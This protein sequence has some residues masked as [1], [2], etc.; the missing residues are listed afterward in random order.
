MAEQKRK[1]YY[2][3]VHGRKP[4]I[5]NKWFGPDGA[6]EQ[7]QDFP[8]AIYKGFY[9][10]EEMRQWLEQFSDTPLMPEHLTE[11]V[12]QPISPSPNEITTMLDDSK[13]IIYTDGAAI[14]NPGSGGY[15]VVLL[16]KKKRKE[17][18]GGFRLTTNN[19]MELLACIAGLKELKFRCSVI[20]LS[21]S[22]YVV[23]G[24]TKG[25]AQRWKAKGWMRTKEKKAE[26]F[27][28]WS[29]LLDIL[30]QHDI[31]FRWVKG[32]SGNPDNERCD[33]LAMDAAARQD[34]P[35]DTMYETL[36][37]KMKQSAIPAMG[38][39][40]KFQKTNSNGKSKIECE[41]QP[42]RKCATPVLKCIP[43][44]HRKP[45]QNYYYE[46]Y[47]YCPKC[48]TMYMVKEAKRYYE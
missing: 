7:I 33:Q 44:A 22:K 31:E 6:A 27:D 26:N 21:D 23:D 29:E 25:W 36:K 16:H 24:I 39:R 5:Y 34:L 45:G 14:N 46:Y 12:N 9:T 30:D 35:P 18:S 4:G 8:E 40:S 28:L 2:A 17:L 15:G 42:C 32:H 47:L 10:A 43:R 20:L 1:Q 37:A 48:H 41:G 38:D 13:V 11:L 19:R 3:V